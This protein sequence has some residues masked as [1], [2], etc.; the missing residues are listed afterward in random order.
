MDNKE[1]VALM[2]GK[3]GD[4]TASGVAAAISDFSSAQAAQA[5]EDLGAAAEPEVVN[6]SG[7]TPTITPADNTVYKCG[8]LTSLTVSNPP[9]TGRY[10]IWFTSGATATAVTGIDNFTPEANKVYRISVEDGYATYDSWAT[11]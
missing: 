2:T 6:V 11:T 8:T 7:A 4:V 5:R 9:A 1:L 10:V 3:G